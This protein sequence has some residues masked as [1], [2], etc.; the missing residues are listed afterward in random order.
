MTSDAATNARLEEKLWEALDD[1]PF[2]MLGLQGVDDDF[3]RP[4]TAQVDRP[5][6]AD[7]DSAGQIYFFAA[8]SEDLV[9][10][11]AKSSKAI[12][13]FAA[14]DHKLFA[15]I[16][17]K[18]V[19]DQDRAVIDRLWNPFI[20][21]WYKDGKGDPDLAL[22]RFDADKA[23]VWEAAAGTT[24][25]AAAMKTLF[26]VDPGKEHQEDHRAEVAL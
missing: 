16:H 5:D 8:H 26:N 15:S 21:S 9:K 25:K 12:A 10:S 11:L 2:V 7:K 22:I 4:M 18:L 24:L 19:L 6:G 3:T 13:T 17:G 20:A 23:D 14:K 1:S